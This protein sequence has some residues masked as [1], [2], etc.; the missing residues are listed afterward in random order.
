[1]LDDIY[2]TNLPDREALVDTIVTLRQDKNHNEEEI[3]LLKVNNAR[4][5]KQLYS[6]A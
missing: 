4:L 2:K 5:K 3:R 1:V 6:A